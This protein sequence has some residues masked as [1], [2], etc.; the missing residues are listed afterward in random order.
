MRPSSH[1]SPSNAWCS[2]DLFNASSTAR[3]H[4]VNAVIAVSKV[5]SQPSRKRP[6]QQRLLQGVK[7]GEFLLV[8]GFQ[9][10]RFCCNIV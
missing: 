2:R 7:G 8:D 3:R 1:N 9:K 5:T 10:C 6:V 4:P